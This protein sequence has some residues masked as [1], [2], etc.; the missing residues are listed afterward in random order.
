MAAWPWSWTGPDGRINTPIARIER[1]GGEQVAGTR[2]ALECKSGAVYQEGV[3]ILAP[4]GTV[5]RRFWM[6]DLVRAWDRQG[7]AYAVRNDCDPY[8]VNGIDLLTA[9]AAAR[10]AGTRAGDLVVSLRSSSSLV[11]LD[12][13]SGAIRRILSGPMVAQHSPNVMADGRLAVFDNL[14]GLDTQ[15]G[16]RIVAMDPATGQGQT[17]F[18]RQ[19]G[20]PG[21]DLH[22]EAQ[23]ALALSADG[24]RGLVAETLGGR[25]FEF[26]IATGA[27][28]WTYEAVS[29]LAPYMALIGQ[30]GDGP[31][32]AHMQTQG[33]RYIRAA[34]FARFLAGG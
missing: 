29:D 19:K 6:A 30:P 9:A 16:T 13:D 3:Q 28:L 7:R 31:R 25:V 32:F 27:P 14:G 4:D 5:L 17:L 2:Q 23:G 24:R 20:T 34:D 12:P 15:N 1:G 10:L 11:V 8:H 26:D 33:A 18:P 21:A 22:S